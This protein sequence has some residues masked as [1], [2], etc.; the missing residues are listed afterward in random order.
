[1]ESN[2]AASFAVEAAAWTASQKMS[3]VLYYQCSTTYLLGGYGVLGVST[4]PYQLGDYFQRVYTNLPLH[5]SIHFS[6]VFW[7]IDSWDLNQGGHNDG[8]QLYFDG[9]VIDGW[10]MSLTTFPTDL[11]GVYG[12]GWNELPNILIYGTVAHKLSTLTFRVVSDLNEPSNNESFGF[13]NLIL[14]FDQDTSYTTSLCATAPITLPD[15]NCA[16]TPGQYWTGS[17]CAS[18]TAPCSTCYGSTTS[19]CYNCNGASNVFYDGKVCRYCDSTCA[20]CTGPASTQCTS[21]AAGYYYFSWTNE[22]LI[23]CEWPLITSGTTCYS[24]CAASQYVNPDGTCS[25]T[26]ASLLVEGISETVV[27]LCRSPCSQVEYLYWDGTCQHDCGSPLTITYAAANQKICNHNCG[28]NYL[29]FDGTCVTS[30]DAPY[31]PRTQSEKL[32][33]MTPCPLTQYLYWNGDCLDSCTA[34]LTATTVG[35]VRKCTYPCLDT[36]YL[37]WDSTCQ[38]SCPYPLKT[39]TERGKMYCDYPTSTSNFLYWDGSSSLNCNLP[40]TQST[41]GASPN[42]RKLCNFPCSTWNYL[43]WDNTCQAECPFPLQRSINL[44]RNYCN[45]ICTG[46]DSLYWDGS[47]QSGCIAPLSPR[48]DR[49]KDFCDYPCTTEQF[50]YADGS[51]ASSCNS[52][53]TQRVTNSRNFCDFPCSSP[54]PYW[55]WNSTCQTSCDPPLTITTKYS[56]SFCN[57]PCSDGKYLYYN[58]SCLEFCD[59]PFQAWS[60]GIEKYCSTP[61]TLSTDFYYWNGSCISTCSSPLVQQTLGTQNWCV[62]PCKANQF[63]YVDGSCGEVCDTYL[64][65]TEE[66]GYKYCN[67]PCD[68]TN[69]F[70]YWNGSCLSSCP[71]PFRNETITNIGKKCYKPCE[72]DLFYYDEKA[73]VC[74][75]TCANP[76]QN[77]SDLYLVCGPAVTVDEAEASTILDLILKAPSST[78]E[79]TLVTLVK[80]M[81]YIRY[82][83]MGVPPR[84]ERF[85]QSKGRNILS[86]RYGQ[87]EIESLLEKFVSRPLPEIFEKREVH[88]NF[89]INFWQEITSWAVV[90]IAAVLFTIFEGICRIKGWVNARVFFE[91]LNTI[92]KWNFCLI[93]VMTSVNDIIFYGVV[94]LTSWAE[95]GTGS[96]ALSTFSLEVSLVALGIFIGLIFGLIYMARAFQTA[97]ERALLDRD[98]EEL[99]E[100]L[101]KRKDSQVLYRGFRHNTTPNKY[102]LVFYIMRM[103]L[104]ALIAALLYSYP[105]VQITLYLVI[106]VAIL[107]YIIVMKPLARIINFIQLIIFESIMLIINICLLLLKLNFGNIHT[108]ALIGDLVIAGNSIINLIAIVF[109]IFKLLGGIKILIQYQRKQPKTQWTIFLQLIPLYLQQGGMGFEEMFIDAKAAEAYNQPQYLIKDKEVTAETLGRRPIKT[110]SG[111]IFPESASE[112]PNRQEKANQLY[113]LLKSQRAAGKE[114]SRNDLGMERTEEV[115]IKSSGSLVIHPQKVQEDKG[116]SLNNLE[117]TQS[118]SPTLKALDDAGGER[119]LQK[120]PGGLSSDSQDSPLRVRNNIKRIR[121]LLQNRSP[122]MIVEN[123]DLE[124][125]ELE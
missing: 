114:T 42:T 26:C 62:Y 49:G 58:S 55:Y 7:A 68:A 52:P 108:K 12:G 76:S 61:C 95:A 103:S 100:F 90:V 14:T 122:A 105:M 89:L 77:K 2:D 51:C 63:L 6:L 91:K 119:L 23:K 110:K 69:E 33:C 28:S 125:K 44:G 104:P 75:E 47:C 86:I 15:K 34:L 65:A 121:G 20:S 117:E 107:G 67:S 40:F 124:E 5:N 78:G 80:Q 113:S 35:G 17:A 60:Y 43:Y 11:C 93:L 70:L 72:N 74:S 116:V 21:C 99:R 38:S 123:Q 56:K 102:F 9:N 111:K 109:L 84:L 36:Q 10:H 73:G 50:L 101:T 29:N 81:Q 22:C 19:D 3:S 115:N 112:I 82:I 32:I 37:Y 24:P 88:S 94:E 25:S 118:Y 66:A 71:S 53:F 8:F 120:S 106:N 16:C 48:T 18:C 59:L 1:M 54:T 79:V 97:R 27:K 41:V 96:S 4:S 98:D 85:L 39:R 87:E 31:I 45:Y 57:F 30:C 83:D 46:T 92:T 64:V 13:R